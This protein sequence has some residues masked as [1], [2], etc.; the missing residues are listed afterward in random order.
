MIMLK[1]ELNIKDNGM[2]DKTYVT[3]QLSLV[4]KA[5]RK[6]QRQSKDKRE[7]HLEELAEYFASN[8]QTTKQIEINKIKQSEK[9]RTT[10][11][12]HKWYLKERHGMIRTLLVQEYRLHQII[13]ILGVLDLI[14]MME[15]FSQG[16]FGFNNNV[17]LVRV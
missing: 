1:G 5:L 12:K 13:S 10:A 9:I 17:M 14:A 4:L 15:A 8:R 16:E 2:E 11:A 3:E 7:A 6:V